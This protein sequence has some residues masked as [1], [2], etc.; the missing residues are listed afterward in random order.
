MDKDIINIFGTFILGIILFELNKNLG[1]YFPDSF[2]T[3][4]NLA[5][6]ASWSLLLMI[7][8]YIL[9]NNNK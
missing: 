6:T 2:K 9:N 4:F 7:I 8:S 1:M 5:L 3:V